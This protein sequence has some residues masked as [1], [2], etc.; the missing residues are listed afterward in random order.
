M[1]R[2][3]KVLAAIILSTQIAAGCSRERETA[4]PVTRD[5]L[6]AIQRDPAS[7][8]APVSLEALARHMAMSSTRPIREGDTL[9]AIKLADEIRKSIAKY[10]DTAAAVADGYEHFENSSTEVHFNKYSVPVS[11]IDPEKPSAI[12]YQKTPEGM[13]LS[14][15]M[16]NVAGSE[17]DLE[18]IT[19]LSLVR[20]HRHV[21]FCMPPAAEQERWT[22]KKS[23]QLVFGNFGVSSEQDCRKAGG[24][25]YRDL[26]GWMV[27][28]NVFSASTIGDIWGG[29]QMGSHLH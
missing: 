11:T 6:L 15:A 14:G 8:G 2:L 22:E 9:R 18:A 23:G 26:S 25:F 12:L 28:A 24:V 27:H 1:L 16:Y 7:L 3:A 13:V 4:A 17:A 10:S 20:W 29:T 21:N 5:V 19:P